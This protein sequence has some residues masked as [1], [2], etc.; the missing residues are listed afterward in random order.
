VI[1]I[2]ARRDRL[3][4]YPGSQGRSQELRE[5]A[6]A[7]P[8]GPFAQDPSGL[9]MDMRK[10]PGVIHSY[11]AGTPIKALSVTCLPQNQVWINLWKL[12]IGTAGLGCCGPRCSG[13][14]C[15]RS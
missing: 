12:W 15:R 13:P 8:V 1:A 9:S 11:G 2:I 14:R 6:G 7:G 5:G 10:T 4:K 3:E